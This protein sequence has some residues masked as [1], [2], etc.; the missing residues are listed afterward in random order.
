MV[1]GRSGGGCGGGMGVVMGRP[2]GGRRVGWG[3]CGVVMGVV[4]G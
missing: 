3:G 1:V 4:V 2:G